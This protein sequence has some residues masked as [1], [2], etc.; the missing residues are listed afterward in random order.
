MAYDYMDYRSPILERLIAFAVMR[1]M[2]NKGRIGNGQPNSAAAG[3]SWDAAAAEEFEKYLRRERK[4][5]DKQKPRDQKVG[6]PSYSQYQRN[7][8]QPIG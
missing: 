4:T 6:N 5:A 3:K 2:Y 7:G 8:G 1:H